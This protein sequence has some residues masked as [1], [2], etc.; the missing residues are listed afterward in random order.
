MKNQIISKLPYGKDFLFVDEILEVDNQHI[1]GSYFFSKDLAFYASHFK[2][3]PVTPGVILTE[4]AAQIGLACFGIYLTSI[5]KEVTE[6][7]FL[8]LS[9]NKMDFFKPVY[10]DENV[11]VTAQLVYFR[12]NKLKVEVEIKL[13]NKQIVAKGI[14]AG[15]LAKTNRQNEQ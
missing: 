2:S 5:E 13:A 10:P 1:K 8:V 9:E 6:N 14:L 7:Q 12:F 4:C 15:M 3:Q 11:Y